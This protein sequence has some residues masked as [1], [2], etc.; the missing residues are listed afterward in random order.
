LVS[1]RSTHFT[2]R[3]DHGIGCWEGNHRVFG[4]T[5]SDRDKALDGIV[6]MVDAFFRHWGDTEKMWSEYER[7]GFRLVIVGGD[8]RLSELSPVE[9]MR[10]RRKH[11]RLVD[12]WCDM[13]LEGSKFDGV[14]DAGAVDEGRKLGLFED[15]LE[16]E[17]DDEVIE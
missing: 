16:D 8:L 11:R 3:I 9:R 4:T 15:M 13:R 6:S 17:G 2:G 5:C 7:G 12:R 10:Y 1:L 14:A